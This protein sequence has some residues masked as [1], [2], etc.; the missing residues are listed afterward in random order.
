[1]S[2]LPLKTDCKLESDKYKVVSNSS[3]YNSKGTVLCKN[4]HMFYEDF[5]ISNITAKCEKNAEWSFNSTKLHCL[6]G[7]FIIY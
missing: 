3:H 1:M 6:N 4:G 5:F 2:N 7:L